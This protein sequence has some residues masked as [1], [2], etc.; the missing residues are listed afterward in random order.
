MNKF[1]LHILSKDGHQQIVTSDTERD[2]KLK[3]LQTE[4]W[5]I[6]DTKEFTDIKLAHKTKE[7]LEQ[8][9]DFNGRM[10][11]VFA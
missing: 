10:K 9:F 7:L 5:I 3:Q 1:Y 8:S 11:N 6:Q 2:R 4:G